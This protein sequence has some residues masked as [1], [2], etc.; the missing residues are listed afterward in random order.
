M[1]AQDSKISIVISNKIYKYTS[2][3]LLSFFISIVLHILVLFTLAFTLQQT[4]LTP[5]PSSQKESSYAIKL[6]SLQTP[7]PKKVVPKKEEAKITKQKIV[8]KSFPTLKR[9]K[10]QIAKNSKSL[11]NEPKQTPTKA[12]VKVQTQVTTTPS[13]VSLNDTPKISSKEIPKKISSEVSQESLLAIRS[14]IEKSL[15]YPSMARRLR[16]EGVVVVAFVLQKDGKVLKAKILTPSANESLNSKAIETV[17]ALS[18]KY[19]L[20]DETIKLKI[21]IAF[22]LK[23]S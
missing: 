22:S 23:N 18:G 20:F 14:L 2:P 13:L 3:K 10:L 12:L 9:A 16:I 21:P 1:Q 15:T 5:M 4:P 6:T 8:K 19:P 7:L 17:L 11:K